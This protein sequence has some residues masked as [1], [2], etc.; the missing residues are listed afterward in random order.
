MTLVKKRRPL[1]KFLIESADNSY[2]TLVL[3]VATAPPEAHELL[4]A[5]LRLP[6]GEHAQHTRG[7][8]QHGDERGE[9]SEEG[10]QDVDPPRRCNVIQTTRVLPCTLLRKKILHRT[11]PSSCLL[12]T[13][14]P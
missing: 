14:L 11:G 9:H 2:V 5:A 7:K 3:R 1:A 6:H 8:R 10:E 4:R 12:P 13:S